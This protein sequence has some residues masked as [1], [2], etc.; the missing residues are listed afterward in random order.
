MVVGT[1]KTGFY[2]AVKI[3][4]GQPSRY[5][6]DIEN[7]LEAKE[8]VIPSEYVK[9]EPA[10]QTNGSNSSLADELKKLKDLFDAGA[11]TKEEYD[12]AKKKLLEN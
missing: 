9:K 12:A 1:K 6:I 2:I 8:V 7:A 3:K 11:I 5:I 4:V 10:K